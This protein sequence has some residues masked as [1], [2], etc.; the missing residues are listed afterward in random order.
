MATNGTTPR[1]DLNSVI[2][3]YQ[4]HITSQNREERA[5]AIDYLEVFAKSV[6]R[7]PAVGIAP[8]TQI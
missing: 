3:A 4:L 8:L 6:R 2:Q 5:Q 7:I 1:Y